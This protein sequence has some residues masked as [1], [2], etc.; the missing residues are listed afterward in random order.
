M[1]NAAPILRERE[2]TMLAV[3][4]TETNRDGWPK[5]PELFSPGR[6]MLDSRMVMCSVH[7]DGV[8]KQGGSKFSLPV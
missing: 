6:G 3:C 1:L 7:G 8:S 4:N 5:Q 2:R